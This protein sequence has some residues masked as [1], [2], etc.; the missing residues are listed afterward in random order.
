M[1][2]VSIHSNKT[3]TKTEANPA[4]HLRQHLRATVNMPTFPNPG[5]SF[6][7]DGIWY[8]YRCLGFSYYKKVLICL[9]VSSFV[10]FRCLLPIWQ[11]IE[12]PPSISS[13]HHSYSSGLRHLKDI[14]IY[15]FSCPCL[16]SGTVI[17]A[18]TIW[19]LSRK[20]FLYLFSLHFI[21][22]HPGKLGQGA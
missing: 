2:I 8:D 22:C 1:V 21:V 9:K 10:P 18:M 4:L 17:N 3:Q 5:F 14:S 15:V 20:G 13:R 11:G 19:N 7:F 6:L 12:S 16:F